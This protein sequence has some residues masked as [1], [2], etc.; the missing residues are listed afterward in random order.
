MVGMMLGTRTYRIPLR[1]KSSATGIWAYLLHATMTVALL[2]REQIISA[3]SMAQVSSP[4]SVPPER[5]M[6]SGLI[7]MRT[8]FR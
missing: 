4:P 3:F 1:S 2:W 7:S 5:R 6:M 8:S